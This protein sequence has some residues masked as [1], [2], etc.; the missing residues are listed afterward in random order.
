MNDKSAIDGTGQ[1]GDAASVFPQLDMVEDSELGKSLSSHLRNVYHPLEAWYLRST[2]ERVGRRDTLPCFRACIDAG[3]YSQAHQMDEVDKLSQPPLSSSLDD[4]FYIL[5]KTIYRVLSTSSID[6]V[7]SMARDIR[8]IVE[9]DV[10]DV[11]RL[12]LDGAFKDVGSVSG[13]GRAREEEK[14]RKEREAT[15]TFMVRTGVTDSCHCLADSLC[16]RCISMTLI[17]QRTTP[18]VLS[19]KSSAVKR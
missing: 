9:K 19:T 7:V 16:S 10:A 18:S 8:Q 12:R 14:E 11:W 6:T 1:D 13:V 2:I 4:T 3:R 5:K 15:A 17:R